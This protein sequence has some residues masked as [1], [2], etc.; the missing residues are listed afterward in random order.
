M[1]SVA[2]QSQ[3]SCPSAIQ[4]TKPAENR[5]EHGPLVGDHVTQLPLIG[6][7]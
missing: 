1:A 7:A 2:P 4:I 3:R 6:P 5:N